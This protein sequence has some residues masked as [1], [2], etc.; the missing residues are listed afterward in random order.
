MPII[1]SATYTGSHVMLIGSGQFEVNLE[2]GQR[3][4]YRREYVKVGSKACEECPYLRNDDGIHIECGEL[5]IRPCM[6]V[7]A[8]METR[9]WYEFWK[10][11]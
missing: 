5:P 9:K 2:A 6:P 7:N 4:P 1:K 8:C 3:C 10:Q 11:K